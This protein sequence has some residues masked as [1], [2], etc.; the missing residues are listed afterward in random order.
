MPSPRTIGLLNSK[1]TTTSRPLAAAPIRLRASLW[2]TPA[3]GWRPCGHAA[4]VRLR[5]KPSTQTLFKQEQLKRLQQEF[6]ADSEV[7]HAALRGESWP[8]CTPPQRCG[9]HAIC[10]LQTTPIGLLRRHAHAVWIPAQHYRGWL[11]L[12]L[13]AL[14]CMALH[15]LRLRTLPPS[16]AFRWRGPANLWHKKSRQ[17]AWCAPQQLHYS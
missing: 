10:R 3:C 7:F 13:V 6:A 11:L 17:G 8:P 16:P 15:R 12:R 4:T 14:F 5:C 9:S 1:K 2:A